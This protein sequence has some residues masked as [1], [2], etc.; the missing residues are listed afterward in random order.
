MKSPLKIIILAGGSG[1]RLWPLSTP[2]YPKQFLMI[3]PGLSLLQQT[4]QRFLTLV[5]W[6]DLFIITNQAFKEITEN[7]ASLV[8]PKLTNQVLFEPCQKNTGFAIT[9]G[10]RN[11][12]S[13]NLIDDDQLVLISPADHIFFSETSFL[14]QLKIA[15]EWYPKS[16]IGSFGYIPHKISQDF[17]YVKPSGSINFFYEK[18]TGFI[19]K[20]LLSVAKRLNKDRWLWNMGL[21]LL[22][23]SVLWR[24]LNES[25]EIIPSNH[26]IDLTIFPSISIDHL[27]IEKSSH[28]SVFRIINAQWMD[29]GSLQTFSFCKDYF[30]SHQLSPETVS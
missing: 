5:S 13:Q 17:G 3:K 18:G 26:P 19:E 6:K 12:Q 11:L 15:I 9:W 21:Y 23:P 2:S 7:Q 30:F 16:S 4:L 28:L 20:P 22:T 29:V 25:V 10:L 8:H 1:S 27:L 14:N 24:S